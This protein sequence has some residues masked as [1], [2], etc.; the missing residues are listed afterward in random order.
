MSRFYGGGLRL[1][2]GYGVDYVN[3]MQLKVLM[4]NLQAYYR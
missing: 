2:D 3:F 4:N 1:E